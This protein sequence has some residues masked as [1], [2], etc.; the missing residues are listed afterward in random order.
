VGAAL[1][2]SESKVQ[3]LFSTRSVFGPLHP[4]TFLLGLL[5]ILVGLSLFANVL[6]VFFHEGR[7]YISP[8]IVHLSLAS[9]LLVQQSFESAGGEPFGTKCQ[10]FFF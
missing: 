10:P 4:P 2:P 1:L 6:A 8:Q 3:D 5:P 9:T 7:Q